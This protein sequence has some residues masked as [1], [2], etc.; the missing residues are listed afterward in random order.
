M[1]LSHAAHC[2]FIFVCK[3]LSSLH[4]ILR[5]TDQRGAKC[6]ERTTRSKTRNPSDRWTLIQQAFDDCLHL[7]AFDDGR[8]SNRI[9]KTFV[10]EAKSRLSVKM[11]RAGFRLRAID[12]VFLVT[13]CSVI[14]NENE[15]EIESHSPCLL[16]ET[17]G[18]LSG[19]CLVDEL[20]QSIVFGQRFQDGGGDGSVI[21]RAVEISAGG[22]EG[23]DTAEGAKED[24]DEN[25]IVTEGAVIFFF[26]QT[27]D[28]CLEVLF[29]NLI[30]CVKIP[31]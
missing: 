3:L 29:D 20:L 17:L 11:T 25:G 5:S 26:E 4:S 16:E 27:G 28:G 1:I 13:V 31:S 30:T 18:Q 2:S 12:F 21:G 24:V 9:T 15:N 23:L 22:E 14:G 6:G 10:K 7:F 8:K 19:K